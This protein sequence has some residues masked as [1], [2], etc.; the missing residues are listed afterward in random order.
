MST[1]HDTGTP[2]GVS[3]SIDL[4]VDL[5]DYMGDDLMVVNAARVSHDKFHDIL[6]DGDVKLIEGLARERHQSPFFHPQIQFRITVPI[7]VGAQLKRHQIGLAL[8]ESSR[9]YISRNRPVCYYPVWRKQSSKK[10]QGSTEEELSEQDQVKWTNKMKII[11]EEAIEL[12]EEMIDSGIAAEQARFVLPQ[13]VFTSWIWTGS[14]FAYA[15]LCMYRIDK[16]A[17]K[18]TRNIAHQIDNHIQSLFYHSWSTLRRYFN[19][20]CW[21]RGLPHV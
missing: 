8:N 11:V 7:A 13:G 5:L 15:N 19:L 16:H 1:N 21:R 18:E 10:H 6:T 14:I 12:Y 9:R 3:P 17:Q 2:S 4:K 20:E